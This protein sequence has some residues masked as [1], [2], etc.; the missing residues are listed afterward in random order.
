MLRRVFLSAAVL[1]ALATAGEAG[2]LKIGDAAPPL[3]FTDWIKGEPVDIACYLV[4]Q[5]G[6]GH[7]SCAK[8]CAE[9]GLPIG[10]VTKGEDGEEQLYLVVGPDRK[11]A[12]DYMAAHMGKMVEAKGTVVEKDGLKILTVSEVTG[13]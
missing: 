1:A 6:E 3:T 13:D 5:R 2:D 9:K 10:F 12:K 11:P 8:S 7:A 4:G